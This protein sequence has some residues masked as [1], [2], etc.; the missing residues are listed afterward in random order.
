M[1]KLEEEKKDVTF[2]IKLSTDTRRLV[3][4]E[5]EKLGIT[6]SGFIRHLII[7][8][9]RRSDKR[10]MTYNDGITLET[11]MEQIK[12]TEEKFDNKITKLSEDIEIL[13]KMVTKFIISK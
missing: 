8:Y 2:T 10:L 4:E 13:S 12:T 6:S 3:F 11:V 7:D 9:T 1:S 5:S